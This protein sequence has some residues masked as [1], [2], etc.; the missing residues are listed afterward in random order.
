MAAGTIMTVT[1]PIAPE[2]LGPTLMHEH[3]LCDLTNPLWRGD[4]PAD[5]EINLGNRH[6]LDYRPMVPGHHV[7]QDRG[8]AAQD[9]HAFRDAGGHAI[10]DLT[11]GGIGPDPTGLA[12]LS[13]ETGVAI[14]LGAGFYTDAYV[15]DAIKELPAEALAEIIE[16][17]VTE[18]AWGTDIPAA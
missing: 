5:L 11:T 18:G 7:L 13:R 8:I 6:E 12:A 4:S 17:Q 16:S 1:G 14:V 3:V 2:A 10:V 9:L 15:A